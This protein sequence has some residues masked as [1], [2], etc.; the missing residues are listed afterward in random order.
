MFKLRNVKPYWSEFSSYQSFD[1]VDSMLEQIKIF[2]STYDLT[3]AAKAVLN[4]IKL[5]SKQFVGVCWLYREEIAKKAKV[6]LSS[7]KRTIKAL[8]EIGFLSVYTHIHTKRGGQTH[9]IYVL[10]PIFEPA[11]EPAN[12]P[13]QEDDFEPEKPVVSSVSEPNDICYKNTDK[14]SNTKSKDISIKGIPNE[15]INLMSSFYSNKP[16]IIRDR[17]KTVC[18]A[19]KKSCNKFEYTSWDTIGQAWKE[20]VNKYKRGHIKNCTDDGLGAYFY[21]VL[22]DYLLNDWLSFNLHQE[23]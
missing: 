14:N 1:S 4:T 8:K 12:E 17:W 13:P 20:T 19:V 11:S 16:E 7:V 9:N 21:G 15:F 22:C 10:N 18:V 23:G 2:E 6:S 5:H 3:P